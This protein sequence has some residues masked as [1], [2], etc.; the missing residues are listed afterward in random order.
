MPTVW[1]RIVKMIEKNRFN[2]AIY[3]GE[4]FH[5]RFVPKSHKFKYQIMMFWL[6]L[7][8]IDELD[9]QLTLFKKNRFAWVQY[10]RADFLGDPQTDLKQAVL[11]K[12]SSLAN[13]PLQGKVYLLSP[14]RI[15]GMYFS[16]VNFYYLQNAHGE[17]S[18]LLAEVSNTPWNER[19]CYLVDLKTQDDAKKA[20]HV[21]PYNP[22]D[23][24][25][26]WRI[27]KPDNTLNLTLE[28]HKQEKYFMAAIALKKSP[29]SNTSM[30]R[31]LMQFPSMTIKTVWGIYWQA[32]KLFCKRM[33]I[34]NHPGKP[35]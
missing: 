7:D 26:Q 3:A 2:S 27:S 9:N 17:F 19:H 5:E 34:Y 12:M 1:R 21:S 10:K 8:E 11:N 6:D 24:I 20:F 14:L 30:R 28:C 13:Q 32:I 18:H 33:P 31:T 25:Y 35:L 16:P 15:L 29:L 22:I 23:M 4:T